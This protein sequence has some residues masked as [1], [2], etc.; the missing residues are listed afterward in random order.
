M[1]VKVPVITDEKLLTLD[2]LAA[3]LD[4]MA[5]EVKGTEG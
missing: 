1:R 4:E 2:E 5:E 3:E